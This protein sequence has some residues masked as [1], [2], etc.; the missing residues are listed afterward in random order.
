MGVF[1]FPEGGLDFDDAKALGAFVGMS[2]WLLFERQLREILQCDDISTSIGVNRQDL[3]SDE[4]GSEVDDE[5]QSSK[6]QQ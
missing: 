6:I 2:G 3:Q 1:S 5:T 4:D